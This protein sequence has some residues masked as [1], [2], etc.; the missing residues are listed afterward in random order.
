[1]Y[2]EVS[3]AVRFSLDVVERAICMA[4]L[5]QLVCGSA[6]VSGCSFMGIRECAGVHGVC[7]TVVGRGKLHVIL[8]CLDK[9]TDNP[10]VKRIVC[11]YVPGFYGWFSCGWPVSVP[12]GR[13]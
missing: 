11:W 5:L 6:E 8:R 3:S 13:G 10:A 7:C 9:K 1:M 2:S 4:M 12:Y